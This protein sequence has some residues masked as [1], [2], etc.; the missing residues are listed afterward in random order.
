MPAMATVNAIFSDSWVPAMTCAMWSA[1]LES[2]PNGCFS[3][4]AAEKSSLKSLGP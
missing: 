2:V 3:E 1:P 4:G